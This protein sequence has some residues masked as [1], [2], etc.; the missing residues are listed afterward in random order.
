MGPVAR[1]VGKFVGT[2]RDGTARHGTAPR[3]KERFE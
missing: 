1:R 2:A 3:D